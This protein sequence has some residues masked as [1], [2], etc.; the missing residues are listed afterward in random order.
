MVTWLRATCLCHIYCTC[1]ILYL[2]KKIPYNFY[3]CLIA[4]SSYCSIIMHLYSIASALCQFFLS[5]L[6]TDT[7]QSKWDIKPMLGQCWASV[8][9]GRPP[10]MQEWVS[11][12][13]LLICCLTPTDIA[14]LS[15]NCRSSTVH[16]LPGFW[17]RHWL[18]LVCQIPLPRRR[19]ST[20]DLWSTSIYISKWPPS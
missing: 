9:D 11:D 12:S 10:L 19:H 1:L 6:N 7:S 16:C 2:I 4:Y 17:V 15:F 5:I 8:V 3:H 14:P 13:R 18:F 20:R